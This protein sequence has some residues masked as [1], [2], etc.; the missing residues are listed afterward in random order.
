[1]SSPS[2]P[3]VSSVPRP[4]AIYGDG[5]YL[6]N[7]PAWHEADSPWK[8]RQLARMIRAHA[9]DVRTIAEVGCGAGEVLR[10]LAG[11]LGETVT[12]TGFETSGQAFQRCRDK[13]AANLTYLQED[14]LTRAPAEVFDLLLV[15]DVVEHVED[16]L[17]FLRALRSRGVWK[18]LHI[19]LDLSVQAALRP[20]SFRILRERYGHL[21]YF[22][23]QTALAAL[24][25]CGYEIIDHVYTRTALEL[26]PT[27]RRQRLMRLP[28]RALFALNPDLAARLLG[29][30]S[31]LVLAR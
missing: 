27:S 17:G 8:A 14:F 28:R 11:L 19:P 30:F 25:Q 9:L 2:I 13:A 23:R 26:E 29:G 16:F 20:R 22:T 18:L 15:V 1:M 21:H 5:T 7:N 24:A 4:G 31:L 10:Q 3:S 6:A 12:C